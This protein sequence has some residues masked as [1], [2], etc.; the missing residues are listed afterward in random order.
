M[1]GRLVAFEGIDGSGKSTLVKR[2]P[3]VLQHTCSQKV[4]VCGER[5]SPV[6]SLIQD[7]GLKDLTPFEK[8]FLFAADRAI[9]YERV[10]LPE[11]QAGS[12]VLWDRYVDSAIVYRDVELRKYPSEIV[13]MEF[14]EMINSP[15]RRPDLTILVNVEVKTAVARAL[16]SGSTQPYDVD[17]LRV[18]S[19]RYLDLASTDPSYMVVSGEV[20]E[21]ILVDRVVSI[22]KEKW[23]ELFNRPSS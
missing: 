14:V 22:I 3:D 12:L 1:N 10:F 18:A 21:E 9:T 23:P 13:G 4:F 16:S 11:M 20:P 19:E 2:L 7:V 8:I 6:R 5:Q 17:F 15:F